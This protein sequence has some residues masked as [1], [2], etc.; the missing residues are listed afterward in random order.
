M[1]KRSMTAMTNG[2]ELLDF[3]LHDLKEPTLVVW[4][5]RDDLIP[6]AVGQRIHS[7]IPDS[8]LLVVDGCGHLAPAECWKPVTDGTVNF[9]K[10][11]DP[12]AG[13]ERMVAGN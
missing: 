8:S 13:G 9:L 12:A 6:L 10:A 7:L 3:R 11:K 4:G 2:R 5:S 1:V